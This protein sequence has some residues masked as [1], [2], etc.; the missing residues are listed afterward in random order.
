[1]YFVIVGFAPKATIWLINP[2]ACL[3]ASRGTECRV[4]ARFCGGMQ[5]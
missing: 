2:D 3:A 4:L 5:G 1:M